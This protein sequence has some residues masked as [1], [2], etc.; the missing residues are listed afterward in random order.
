MTFKPFLF[1]AVAAPL[2][3]SQIDSCGTPDPTGDLCGN[4]AVTLDAEG[5]TTVLNGNDV[6]VTLDINISSYRCSNAGCT[7]TG[8]YPSEVLDAGQSASYTANVAPE[9]CTMQFCCDTG[10][11]GESK[12]SIYVKEGACS[13]SAS[14]Q[15][16]T[17]DGGN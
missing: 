6:P 10:F 4:L 16:T 15:R 1:L 8:S 7:W 14:A 5:N 11:I 12:A 9:V 2:G 3:L 13:V 17:C